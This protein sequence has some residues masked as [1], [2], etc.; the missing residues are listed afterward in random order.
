MYHELFHHYQNYFVVLAYDRR[1]RHKKAA[2][3]EPQRR[4]SA[5]H[6]WDTM[7]N[8]DECSWRFATSF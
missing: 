5:W 1:N 8:V 2:V 4:T 7:V 6:V 3:T